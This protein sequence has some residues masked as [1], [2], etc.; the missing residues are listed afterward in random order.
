MVAGLR[1]AGHWA[2]IVARDW[3]FVYNTAALP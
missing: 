2:D 1:D 3:R